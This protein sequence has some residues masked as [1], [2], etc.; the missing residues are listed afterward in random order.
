MVMLPL[1]VKELCMKQFKWRNWM[2]IVLVEQ[3]TLLSII[4]LDLQRIT[5]MDVLQRIVRMLQKQPFAQ[6]SM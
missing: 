5:W 1:L 6:F 3:F 4:K 2:A